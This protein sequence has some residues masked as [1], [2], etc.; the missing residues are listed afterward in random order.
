MYRYNEE[1]NINMSKTF[2]FLP[3]FGFCNIDQ[4]ITSLLRPKLMSI[5]I[6]ISMMGATLEFI[7]GLKPI[8]LLAFVMLL[9]LE[10]MSG[11]FASWIEGKR[12]TSKRMKSFLMMLF[13]WLVILFIL[14]SFRYHFEGK[15][16]EYIF[17]YLFTAVLIF[18]NVIYFKSIWE[19]AGRIMNRKTEFKKIGKVFTTKLDKT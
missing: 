8:V 3:E 1:L 9:T 13:I 11:I 16:M 15:F 14:N 19:N 7:F 6:P 5:S 17:D 2:N 10:L 18:V 12:I 4:F